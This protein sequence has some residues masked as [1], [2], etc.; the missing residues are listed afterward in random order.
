MPGADSSQGV[1]AADGPVVQLG[2]ANP[3]PGAT[4]D[5][6]GCLLRFGVVAD[7]Q[8]ADLD[9]GTNF[10]K[11]VTRYYRDA[12]V[13][14]QQ[15]VRCWLAHGLLQDQE[16]PVA[17]VAQ[18][19]DL[20]DGLNAYQDPP[21][22]AAASAAVMRWLH[23]LTEAGIPVHH[24][25]GNHEVMNFVR[26]EIHAAPLPAE[27]GAGGGPQFFAGG[28]PGEQRR[29]AAAAAAAAAAGASITARPDLA[30]PCAADD[31]G[32]DQGFRSYL[33]RTIHVPYTD[34]KTGA[35]RGT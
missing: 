5:P 8:Y 28:T 7:V 26:G 2:A 18:L 21:Q 32:G 6:R 14:L 9:V 33:L 16:E 34:P 35:N 27:A 1:L 12:G 17:F 20:I 13:A 22:T 31:P 30:F 24:V 4:P 10:M 19:G 15:A 29:A 11:T 25:V 3:P 23:P